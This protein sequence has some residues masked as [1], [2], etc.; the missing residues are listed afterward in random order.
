MILHSERDHRGL[1]IAVFSRQV[2]HD[3]GTTRAIKGL[4]RRAADEELI[5]FD[6]SGESIVKYVYLIDNHSSPNL[7]CQR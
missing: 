2:Y 5:Y 7:I 3:D 4:L 1:G 6:S